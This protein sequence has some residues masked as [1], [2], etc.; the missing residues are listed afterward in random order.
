MLYWYWTYVFRNQSPLY[1]QITRTSQNVNI[2]RQVCQKWPVDNKLFFF[3]F[4][5]MRF[6][7]SKNRNRSVIGKITH[8]RTILSFYLTLPI[9]R[10]FSPLWTIFYWDIFG[11]KYECSYTFE[12]KQ[13]WNNIFTLRQKSNLKNKCG[14]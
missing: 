4:V 12:F 9:W 10:Y 5:Q 13:C 6:V 11:Y 14:Y 8:A 2:C 1:R 7:R 3:F